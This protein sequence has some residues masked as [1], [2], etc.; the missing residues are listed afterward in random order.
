MDFA[1]KVMTAAFGRTYLFSAG[2]AGYIIKSKSGQLL[3]I[4]LYLSD[5]VE[6]IEGQI[7]YKRMLPKILSPYDLEFD[8]VITTH[9]HRDHFDPDSIPEL[10]ANGRTKLFASVDCK[11]DVKRLEMSDRNITYVK[12]GD[13]CIAGDFELDF[14]HCDHGAGAPDAVGVTVTVDGKR[15]LEAGDTCLRLDRKEEY[16]SKGNIDVLIAPINGAYGNMDEQDCAKLSNE[17]KPELTIPCHYGM[18]ASH[19]GNPGKFFDIMREQYPDNKFLIMTQGEML[20]LTER[21]NKV[22]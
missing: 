16:L 7:G 2:Q 11:K 5:S 12:P 9:P 1:A 21:Q 20:I 6:R 4:D 8:V 22:L 18:F 15:I 10:M 17:L 19:G 13:S 14:I 3:A